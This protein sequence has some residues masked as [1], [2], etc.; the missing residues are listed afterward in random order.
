M[1]GLPVQ[2]VHMADVQRATAASVCPTV[3]LSHRTALLESLMTRARHNWQ[4]VGAIS[5]PS[6][7]RS[8]SCPQMVTEYK[9]RVIT[10]NVAA[11]GDL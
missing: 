2:S 9:Q 8:P 7:L 3:C 11:V 6:N 5:R 4:P 10:A 1:E